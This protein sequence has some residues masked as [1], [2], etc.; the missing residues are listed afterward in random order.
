MVEWEL[1]VHIPV[2]EWRERAEDSAQNPERRSGK[3]EG[4][5]VVVRL[6]RPPD[7]HRDSVLQVRQEQERQLQVW[8]LERLY[9]LSLQPIRC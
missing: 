8:Q 9:L 3:G 4:C 2:Q 7:N 6:A 5:F 1:I